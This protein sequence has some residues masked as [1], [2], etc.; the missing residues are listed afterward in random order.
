M[1]ETVEQPLQS[2]VYQTHSLKAS[3]SNRK[4]IRLILIVQH[5]VDSFP[6]I[7]ILY[8]DGVIAKK[9]LFAIFVLILKI[10]FNNFY[11]I[12]LDFSAIG[13]YESHDGTGGGSKNGK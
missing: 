5:E 10:I 2:V 9:C 6:T 1:T 3:N 11:F 13:N 8:A 7:P 4:R 12:F